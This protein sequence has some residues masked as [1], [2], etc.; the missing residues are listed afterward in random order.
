M[1]K[2]KRHIYVH[3]KYTIN[4]KNNKKA[5]FKDSVLYNR[6]EIFYTKRANKVVAWIAWMFN[7][8]I[9]MLNF[10]YKDFLI[11]NNNSGKQE[12]LLINESCRTGIP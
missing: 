7:N 3:Q 6:F 12:S 9:S 2:H 8:Y 5:E 10:I 1:L 11:S 4:F